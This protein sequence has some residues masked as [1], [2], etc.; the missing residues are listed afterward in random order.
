MTYITHISKILETYGNT[1]YNL[2]IRVKCEGDFSHFRE[3]DISS[4]VTTKKKLEAKASVKSKRPVQPK[5]VQLPCHMATHRGN[6]KNR[7][8]QSPTE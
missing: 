8:T 4:P 6:M 7:K 1:F 5:T 3:W 2:L